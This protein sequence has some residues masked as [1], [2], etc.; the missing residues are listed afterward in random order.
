MRHSL[1]V[2][3]LLLATQAAP[4]FADRDPYSGAP[5]PARRPETPSP[6]T[7]HFW[8]RATFYDPQVRTS[9]RVDPTAGAAGVT[10]SALSGENDLGLPNRL[11]QGRVD[12]MFRL[13]QRNKLRVDYF[14]ADRS[15]S[16]VLAND[17]VF[18]NQTFAAGQLAQSSL[19][20]HM[21]DITYTYS[22]YQSDRF[23][24]GTGVALYLL[25][26]EAIGAV[27]ALFQRQD[28]SGTAELPAV[29]LDLAW[30]ISSR[31]ALTARA[32]Y[33]RPVLAGFHGW[34]ADI[35][36]DAQYRWNP[37]LAIG[38]GYSTL[39][40]SLSHD[41]GS[42]RGAFGM[43]ISGPEAFVRFSF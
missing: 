25:Q 13:R 14:E 21:F 10:G 15:G 39:R 40:T 11:H 5:L 3:A 20:W 6:I 31:F 41:G 28:V 19:D 22:L 8:I 38:L 42:F 33:L 43:S 27:P 23:E 2:A 1:A 30:R 17:I 24:A 32:A 7:D 12:F 16:R 4:A 9:L 36:E 26:V 35:H 34:F 37:N 29:P 18:G